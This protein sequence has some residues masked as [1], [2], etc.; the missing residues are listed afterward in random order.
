MK[1]SIRF[2]EFSSKT[3]KFIIIVLIFYIRR[4]SEKLKCEKFWKQLS[5]FLLLNTD[6]FEKK[7]CRNVIIIFLII[8]ENPTS[9]EENT[10]KFLK[11]SKNFSEIF[12]L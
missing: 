6:K 5:H 4:K 11:K 1:N 10:E 2:V 12:P 9:D 8:R 3:A 7:F